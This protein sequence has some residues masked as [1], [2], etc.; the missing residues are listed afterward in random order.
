MRLDILFCVITT[1]NNENRRDNILRTW[2]RRADHLI[3][4]S[5]HHSNNYN[6]IKVSENSTYSSGMEKTISI[7]NLLGQIGY[8]NRWFYFCDDDTF[9]NVAALKE[10]AS[11]A[12]PRYVHCK[13]LILG[14]HLP[15]LEQFVGNLNYPSGGAGFLVHGSLLNFVYP[16][17][18]VRTHYGDVAFGINLYSR[19]IK[20]AWYHDAGRFFDQPPS[21]FGPHHPIET[22]LSYH[23]VKTTEQFDNL[24]QFFSI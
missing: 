20:S 1:K 9:V 10:Y 15:G 13:R 2:G 16:F 8:Q 12:D 6:C 18:Y 21:H 5:D 17:R 4:Y 14:E 11:T 24:A 19:D 22:A 3:F 23:Y 7:L